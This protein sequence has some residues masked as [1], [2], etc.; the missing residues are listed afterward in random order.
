MPT[1]PIEMPSDTLIV[2]NSSGYPP[3][4]C[5]PSLTALAS[6]SSDRLHGVI[7]FQLEATPTWGFAQSSSPIP[8]ARS[9]PRDAVASSPSVTTRDRGL[10][11]TPEPEVVAAGPAAVVSRL[12]AANLRWGADSPASDLDD[13]TRR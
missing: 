5:T 10:M 11:S 3:A 8:T 12:M 4:A 9:I 1:W 7:S 13:E 6:R 2:P